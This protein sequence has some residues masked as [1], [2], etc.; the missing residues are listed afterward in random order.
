[1]KKCYVF[2]FLLCFLSVLLAITAMEIFL[3]LTVCFQNHKSLED[4]LRNLPEVGT[5]SPAILPD[6]LRPSIYPDIVYELRPNITAN[7]AN[8]IVKVNDD[9]FRNK[10]YLREKALGTARIVTLGDSHMFGRGV[11][12]NRRYTDLLEDMLNS[13][14]PTKKWEVINTAVPGYNTFIEV[15]T[16]A[17]K[18]LFF[19][20][21]IV[22]IEYIC[23]DLDLPNFL[24]ERP[25]FLN[26]GRSFLYT[27]LK[28]RFST[29]KVP[30]VLT[31]APTF[32]EDGERLR[33]AGYPSRRTCS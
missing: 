14:F 27:F 5:N 11:A 10:P 12:G 22:L 30:F 8:V 20:P 23:N 17:E 13:S 29:L 32:L 33:F 2:R 18:G 4:A 1:M 21:D 24:L 9:G 7:F 25:D 19:S 31:N 16:L 15:E 28:G 3:R 26:C 6:I